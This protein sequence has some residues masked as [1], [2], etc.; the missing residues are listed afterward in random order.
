MRIG[1]KGDNIYT[2]EVRGTKP[3]AITLSRISQVFGIPLDIFT[4]QKITEKAYREF[5]KNRQFDTS[6]RIQEPVT[7]SREESKGVRLGFDDYRDK[8]ILLLERSLSESESKLDQVQKHLDTL[9]H[10]QAVIAAM[11]EASFEA[12][13]H[14]LADRKKLSK[15][16]VKRS[17]RNRAFSIMGHFSKGIEVE[18]YT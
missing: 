10:R 16:E 12:L 9:L 5:A 3:K 8:Y 18:T 13:L 1:V 14:D 7:E 6:S 2:Y 4:K 11:N 17:V 15:A